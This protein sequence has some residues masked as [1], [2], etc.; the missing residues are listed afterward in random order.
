MGS[1]TCGRRLIRPRAFTLTELLIAVG[2]IALLL[3][4]L[5]PM[6]GR[7]RD[8]ARM[9]L[10][11]A[12]L[13]QISTS[14]TSW[15]YNRGLI[16]PDAG[17]WTGVV[18]SAASGVGEI[19]YCPQGPRP[20][21]RVLLEPPYP[22]FMTWTR[23]HGGGGQ[24]SRDNGNNNWRVREEGYPSD[25]YTFRI[26]YRPRQGNHYVD[27][28]VVRFTRIDSGTWRIE[29]L[30]E[31]LAFITDMLLPTGER[32]ND[33]RAGDVFIISGVQ[34]TNYGYNVM[35]SRVGDRRSEAVLVMDHSK[36][37]IDYMD[38]LDLPSLRTAAAPRHMG[39][40][41]VLLTDGSVRQLTVD[42]LDPAQGHFSVR[43]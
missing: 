14:F 24:G 26:T 18:L 27:D 36:M 20:E 28:C 11:A 9:A 8:H 6:V 2:I 33:I 35:A 23:S 1:F 42:Q 21:G 12:N 31:N 10:C 41:N 15:G 25:Q 34:P 3:S 37:I 29:V 4:L 43:K 39:R 32:F 40:M 17:G 30:A 5:I 38:L 16:L 22:Q 7:A 19:L 13:N